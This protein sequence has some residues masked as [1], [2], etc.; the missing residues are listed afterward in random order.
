MYTDCLNLWHVTV[1][2]FVQ[3][4][5]GVVAAV[6]A[7]SAHFFLFMSKYFPEK[8]LN[9]NNNKY[10]RLNI[11]DNVSIKFQTKLLLEQKYQ[12]SIVL[13]QIWFKPNTG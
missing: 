10:H 9:N 1:M 7:A 11:I 3:S 13:Y 6:S 4:L 8:I 2:C 12:Y 5:H